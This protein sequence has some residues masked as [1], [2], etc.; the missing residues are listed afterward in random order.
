M[1]LFDLSTTVDPTYIISLIRKLV[2]VDARKEGSRQS[3]G[4]NG[5]K[6]GS[7]NG[8]MDENGALLSLERGLDQAGNNEHENMDIVADESEVS[9]A[10]DVWEEHGCVLWDLAEVELMMN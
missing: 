5:I 3:G 4:N 6:G 10:D 7:S 9:Q 8:Y 2:P 1:Q